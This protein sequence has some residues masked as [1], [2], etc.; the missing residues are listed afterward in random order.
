[1]RDREVD[2]GRKRRGRKK[3]SDETQSSSVLQTSAR[4]ILH[5]HSET[6]EIVCFL[7]RLF[8]SSWVSLLHVNNEQHLAVSGRLH[9]L[10]TSALMLVGVFDAPC[11]EAALY[12]SLGS[13]V[14]NYLPTVQISVF[15]YKLRTLKRWNVKLEMSPIMLP[16]KS[17]C[18]IWQRPQG[19]WATSDLLQQWRQ[20][21][22][23][24]SA[25]V[26]HWILKLFSG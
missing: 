19:R 9:F 2:S 18:N 14:C 13:F 10:H 6:S 7:C 26:S 4:G 8:K 20:R 25:N 16:Q 17:F 11:T 15:L 3:W 23:A 5:L 1:M 24:E 21:E 22:D 12:A